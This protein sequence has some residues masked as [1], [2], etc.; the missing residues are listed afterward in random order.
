MPVGLR[1]AWFSAEGL[2]LGRKSKISHEQ[3]DKEFQFYIRMP[4]FRLLGSIIKKDLKVVDILNS[5]FQH[6]I[7]RK[8]HK[9]QFMQP[10]YM[11]EKD[12][13]VTQK[14]CINIFN[15]YTNLCGQIC[16][17]L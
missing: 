15:V 14:I 4:N 11:N 7:F 8:F 13:V 1:R 2:F 5:L 12:D 10:H 17:V 9:I 3:N 6:L 16:V